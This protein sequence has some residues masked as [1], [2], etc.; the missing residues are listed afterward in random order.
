MI[1]SGLCAPAGYAQD[2]SS[3]VVQAA[4]PAAAP[5]R[6]VLPKKKGEISFDDL[7]FDLEKGDPFQRE[8]LPESI[9]KLNDQPVR[10]RGFILPTSVYQQSGIRQFVL[11][12]DNQE[13]CFGP[14]AAL[15]DCVMVYMAEGASAEFSTRPVTVSGKFRVEELKYPEGDGHLAIYRID[16]K[17]V[18]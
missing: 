18:K 12:R 11:V 4:D 9:V 10:L 7:K 2:D 8:M 15:Y 14:G 3:A 5:P 13:C 16:A 1:A 6:R 17:E